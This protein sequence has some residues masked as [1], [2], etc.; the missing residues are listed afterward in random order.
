MGS[1]WGTFIRRKEKGEDEKEKRERKDLQDGQISQP[2]AWAV[3]HQFDMP[4]ALLLA[5]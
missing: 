1:V 3:L 5:S 4:A 2:V